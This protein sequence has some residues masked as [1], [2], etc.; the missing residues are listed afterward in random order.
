MNDRARTVRFV[1]WGAMVWRT[2]LT[3]EPWISGPEMQSDG[4]GVVRGK[5]MS[6]AG[7]LAAPPRGRVMRRAQV[8]VPPPLCQGEAAAQ[9]RSRE[10]THG[11]E[12]AGEAPTNQP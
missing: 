9:N 2:D 5:V 3:R 11:D 6:L 12:Y 4:Q 8:A 1:G 7:Y 10:R